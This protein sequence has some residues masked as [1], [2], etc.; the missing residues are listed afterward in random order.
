MFI[1]LEKMAIGNPRIH[2]ICGICGNN[3]DN[4]KY[5]LLITFK[6]KVFTGYKK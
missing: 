5:A 3:I 4:E 6:N 1:N 2:I